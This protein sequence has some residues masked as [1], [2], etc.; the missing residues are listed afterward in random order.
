MLD[1][2]SIHSRS[3]SHRDIFGIFVGLFS[4]PIAYLS[5]QGDA[6]RSGRDRKKV[7]PTRQSQ[8]KPISPSVSPRHEPGSVHREKTDLKQTDPF[9]FKRL[10]DYI[11]RFYLHYRRALVCA[12]RASSWTLLQNVSKSLYDS[13]EQ[14]IQY[15]CTTTLNRIFPLNALLS[16]GYQTMFIASELLLDMLYRTKPFDN[17]QNGTVAKVNTNKLHQWFTTTECSWASTT[18]RFEQPQDRTVLIDLRL[19]R[20]FILRALH[21]LYVAAKW[22]KLATIAIKFNALS[23]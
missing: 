9:G 22:E 17:D 15:L 23:E 7:S 11:D 10:R 4:N 3:M 12:H 14:L 19:I 13:T 8:P 21:A 16:A 5:Q 1:Y 20:K 18:F 6:L 2:R